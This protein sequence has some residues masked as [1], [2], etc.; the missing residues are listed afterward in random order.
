MR[1]IDRIRK[2]EPEEL[3]PMLVREEVQPDYDENYEGDMV[4]CGN[5]Y[6]YIT[7]DGE[8]FMSEEDAIEYTIEWLLS[9]FVIV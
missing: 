9:E 5:E 6:F 1:K 4:Y 7:P 2:L 3:A 8:R